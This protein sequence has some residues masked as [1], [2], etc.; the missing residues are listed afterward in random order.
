[1]K[2]KIQIDKLKLLQWMNKALNRTYF[3]RRF[4][5]VRMNLNSRLLTQA[6]FL[7]AQ[8]LF[9]ALQNSPK[10]KSTPQWSKSNLYLTK[11][12]LQCYQI[13]HFQMTLKVSLVVSKW[14]NS[15]KPQRISNKV[16]TWDIILFWNELKYVWNHIDDQV[17]PMRNQL[18]IHIKMGMIIARRALT[19]DLDRIGNWNS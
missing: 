2:F 3:L 9:L 17:S 19:A 1:M 14:V 7:K 6:S 13:I 4:L 18:I 15:L 5:I 11:T 16:N 12:I 10:T 8:K